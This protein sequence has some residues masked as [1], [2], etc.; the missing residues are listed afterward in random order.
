MYISLKY[1]KKWSFKSETVFVLFLSQ[2]RSS[3]WCHL[4]I[5]SQIDQEIRDDLRMK[6]SRI[7]RHRAGQILTLASRLDSASGVFK[8]LPRSRINPDIA[9]MLCPLNFGF[10]QQSFS[11]IDPILITNL[12]HGAAHNELNFIWNITFASDYYQFG[13]TILLFLKWTGFGSRGGEG[14][15][16]A[17]EQGSEWKDAEN[18]GITL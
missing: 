17:G 10:L 2:L 3:L 13:I 8:Q 7:D 6:G 12:R 11:K 14:G 18:E 9:E 15:R 4:Y 5:A 1:I 16:G